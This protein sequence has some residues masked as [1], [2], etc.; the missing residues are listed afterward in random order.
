M[1]AI[2]SA[3][4]GGIS[5]IRMLIQSFVPSLSDQEPGSYNGPWERDLKA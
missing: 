2:A 4:S 5:L 1:W 3:L